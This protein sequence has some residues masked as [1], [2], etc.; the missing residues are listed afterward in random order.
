MRRS[1]SPFAPRRVIPHEQD[2]AAEQ[3]DGFH[4]FF[5]RAGRAAAAEHRLLPTSLGLSR[6]DDILPRNPRHRRLPRAGRVGLLADPRAGRAD[7]AGIPV[8]PPAPVERILRCFVLLPPVRLGRASGDRDESHGGDGDSLR[9][10]PLVRLYHVADFA[11]GVLGR[12]GRN[13]GGNFAGVSRGRA[14]P[15]R[16]APAPP[17]ARGCSAAQAVHGCPTKWCHRGLGR[18]RFPGLP[19]LFVH[20][21]A[22]VGWPSLRRSHLHFAMPPRGCRAANPTPRAARRAI[23]TRLRRRARKIR[24]RRCRSENPAQRATRRATATRSRRSSRR[25]T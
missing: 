5:T 16:R 25:R 14:V 2:Q 18:A 7:L 9:A 3:P 8:H 1:A 22:V 17:S 23:A 13:P 12:T 6:R 21:R 19:R 24:E 15:L 11:R 4:D 10:A 20:T